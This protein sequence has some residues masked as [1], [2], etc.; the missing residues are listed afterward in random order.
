MGKSYT[1][2]LRERV[3]G[4]IE[5]GHSRRKGAHRFAVSPSCAVKLMSRWQRTKSLEPARQGRPRGGGKLEPHRG[6]L[7]SR[8]EARPDITMPELA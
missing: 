6:F 7:I 8:V 2:D 1:S 3:V 5:A 4:F